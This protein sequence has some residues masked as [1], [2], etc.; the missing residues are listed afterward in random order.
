MKNLIVLFSLL[1]F[2]ISGCRQSNNADVEQLQKEVWETVIAH[3]DAW[4][5]DENLNEQ[6][7]YVHDNI[8]FVSPPFRECMYGI[9]NYR[10]GYRE[11][12]DHATV[13]FFREINPKI[14]IHGDGRFALVTYNIEMS[15]DYDDRTVEEWKGID[16]ISLVKEEGKWLIT[17]DMF[18]K[19]ILEGAE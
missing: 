7:K 14:E 13:H 16:M 8:I 10:A 17:S 4:S 15:F 5:V 6:M 2:I 11:W 1:I 3:N 19:I 18:A 12:I 9:D